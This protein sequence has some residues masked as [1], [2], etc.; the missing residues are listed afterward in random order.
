M[1]G[2]LLISSYLICLGCG[3]SVSV[4]LW[5]DYITLTWAEKGNR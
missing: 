3:L 5:F 1:R 4:F 2:G